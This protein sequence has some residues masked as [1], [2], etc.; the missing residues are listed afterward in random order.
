[1]AKPDPNAP[2]SPNALR[3]AVVWGTTVVALK[4]LERG[5][6]F[7]LGDRPGNELPVP[8]GV[9]IS[10]EPVRPAVNGWELDVRGCVGGLLTLRGRAEDPVAIARTGAPV[11]VMPGDFGLIQYG[12]IALFFQYTTRPIKMSTFRGPELLLTL[13]AMCSAV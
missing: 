7:T 2:L 12:Q 3:V 13:A 10:P 6:A 8:D 5:E 9:D 4:T 1:M 11:A